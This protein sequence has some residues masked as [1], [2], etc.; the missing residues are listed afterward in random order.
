MSEVEERITRIKTHKGVKGLLIVGDD[1]NIIRNTIA[2][3]SDKEPKTY[4]HLVSDLAKKVSYN[5]CSI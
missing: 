1:G 4:A 3:G 5:Y 2:S